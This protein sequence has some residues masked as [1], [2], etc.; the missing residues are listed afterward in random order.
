MSKQLVN[1]SKFLSFILRHKPDQI[2][3]ELDANGWANIADLIKKSKG[4]PQVDLDESIILQVVA[5]SE[6]K[7]FALSEDG[8]SIRANQGHSLDIDLGLQEQVPPARLYHGTASRFLDSI[9]AQGLQ[10]MNRHHVHLTENEGTATEV[11]RRYGKVVML[12]IDSQAMHSDGC[13][14]FVSENSVWLVDEVPMAY[15]RVIE[16]DL[17]LGV[18]P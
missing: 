5:T 12:E 4:Q 7:R 3:L 17:E 14:F 13:K 10:K 18:Q 16:K 6:K 15:I 8:L 2:G 9:K 1:A 11:G